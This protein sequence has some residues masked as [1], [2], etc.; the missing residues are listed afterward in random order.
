MLL[1]TAISHFQAVVL[2]EVQ[3]GLSQ[4][5]MMMSLLTGISQLRMNF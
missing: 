3:Y 2:M 5:M 4:Q 1:I